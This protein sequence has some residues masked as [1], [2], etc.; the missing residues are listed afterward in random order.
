MKI[1]YGSQIIIY[2]RL[3]LRVTKKNFPKNLTIDQFTSYIRKSTKY[4]GNINWYDEQ[5]R[6]S[7]YLDK[8]KESTANLLIKKIQK[9]TDN[10]KYGDLIREIIVNKY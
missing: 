4:K 8:M 3:V 2:L 6:Y 10:S 5:G 1:T 9:Y 7:L